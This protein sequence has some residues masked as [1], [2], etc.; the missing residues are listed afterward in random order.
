VTDILKPDLE[1]PLF[2]PLLAKSFGNLPRTYIEVV[3]ADSWRDDGFL[4][5]KVLERAGVPTKLK[6]FPG[7]PHAFEEFPWKVS[8]QWLPSLVDG[9]NFLLERKQ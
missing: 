5:Q 4:Y 8:E 2:S 7:V 9:A 1:S 6:V 3:G